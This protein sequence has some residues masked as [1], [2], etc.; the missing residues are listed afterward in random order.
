MLFRLVE[1]PL[2][3]VRL[4]LLLPPVMWTLR[5]FLFLRISPASLPGSLR[6]PLRTTLRPFSLL[7]SLKPFLLSPLAPLALRLLSQ[8]TFRA[9]PSTIARLILLVLQP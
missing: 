7:A 8:L 3:L 2:E 6:A 1:V 4:V 9:L 5:T